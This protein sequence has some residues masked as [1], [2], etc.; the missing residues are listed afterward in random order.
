ML[1]FTARVW[2]GDFG[3]MVSI[4]PEPGEF[5]KRRDVAIKGDVRPC[6]DDR[7]AAN[8]FGEDWFWSEK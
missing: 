6:R 7:D 5:R 3:A 2:S 1:I 4:L 8:V